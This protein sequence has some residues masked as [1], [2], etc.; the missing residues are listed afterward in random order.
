MQIRRTMP[1]LL[2]SG[3]TAL[4]CSDLTQAPDK[5]VGHPLYA[6][7]DILDADQTRP[8]PSSA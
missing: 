7:N 2:V 8:I 3:A 1:L 6:V 4:S 5:V